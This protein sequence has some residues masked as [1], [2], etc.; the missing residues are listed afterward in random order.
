[1]YSC[2]NGSLLLYDTFFYLKKEILCSTS[3]II[4]T[5]LI[6]VKKRHFNENAASV[7]T[8]PKEKIRVFILF[9]L[10]GTDS[11][12]HFAEELWLL[13]ESSH[14][15]LLGVLDASTLVHAVVSSLC[16][17]V[18]A[19]HSSDIDTRRRNHNPQ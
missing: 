19:G 9:S 14:P 5:S 16:T 1:M 11:D 7:N 6:N 4:D 8:I 3:K 2:K 12:H 15:T 18:T 17:Y 13:R 10:L